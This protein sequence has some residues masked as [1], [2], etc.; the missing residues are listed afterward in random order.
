METFVKGDVVVVSF[1]FSD[2]TQTKKR[3]ALVLAAFSNHELLLSEITSKLKTHE[4]DLLLSERDFLKGTLTLIS[5]LRLSRL[6]T[7]ESSIVEYK[8]GSLSAEKLEEIEH[9]LITMIQK[10]H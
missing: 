6:F 2:L 5:T 10:G 4:Y 3:P 1:P 9:L 7:T 8:V